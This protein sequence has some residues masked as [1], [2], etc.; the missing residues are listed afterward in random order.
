MK[1]VLGLALSAALALTSLAARADE[2]PAIVKARAFFARYVELTDAFDP[3]LVALYSDKARAINVRRFEGGVERQME[4][5]G[6]RYKELLA[7]A[8]PIAKTAGDRSTYSDV[9]YA[10]DG[11]YVRIDATRLSQLKHYSSPFSLRIGPI[12]AKEWQIVE[13]RSV[14]KALPGETPPN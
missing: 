2:D 3:Q 11:E 5:Q 14:S 8:L 1:A 13:E 4:L 10:S 6:T 7:K 12:A 9:K